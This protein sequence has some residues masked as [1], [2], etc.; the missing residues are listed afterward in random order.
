[1]PAGLRVEGSLSPTFPTSVVSP[2]RATFFRS[3]NESL[4]HSTSELFPLLPSPAS[5]HVITS[6]MMTRWGIAS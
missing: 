5:S 4:A 2:T 3:A 1:M 6:L